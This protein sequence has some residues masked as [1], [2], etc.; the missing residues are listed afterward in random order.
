MLRIFGWSFV[1]TV[2]SLVAAL[3]YGGWASLGLCL[4]LGVL[5]VSLSFDN[6]VVNASVLNRMSDY[7][8]RIFLTA[9]ILIAVFGM[10]LLLPLLIVGATAH[11]SPA[12]AVRLALD[13]G[14][15]DMPGSYA[16]LLTQAHPQIAAFGSAFLLMLFLDFLFDERDV[17]WLRLIEEPLASLGRFRNLPIMITG[18]LVVLASQVLAENPGTVLLAGLLGLLTYLLVA[19]LGD[20]LEQPED[21][22]HHRSE[23]LKATGR[24]AFFMFLYLEVLDASFSFDGVI[25]AFALTADPILIALGLGF[26]GA[27]YVRSIT[28]YLIRKGTL[29]EYVYLEHGAH[30][31]IG[32]LAL[33]LLLSVGF[34]VPQMLTGLIGVVFII[35]SLWSS[36]HLP[37]TDNEG[38]TEMSTGGQT[39]IA[40]PS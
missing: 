37:R 6:A 28:V 13:K 33:L 32:A 11:L 25:G 12:E 16:Y 26:I 35:A 22:E 14:P 2:V 17:H 3:V 4:I 38:D 18:G 9:G 7:W 34:E 24:A 39:R 15:V 5:E 21:D 36:T 19:G 10:R 20:M 1:V 31:A 8:Q 27:M 23:L 40:S 30:W 29:T